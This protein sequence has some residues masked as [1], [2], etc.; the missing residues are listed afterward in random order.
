MVSH[1]VSHT[2]TTTGVNNE[3]D[4]RSGISVHQTTCKLF[5]AIFSSVQV[6]H[7]V[8]LGTCTQCV[9]VVIVANGDLFDRSDR[10]SNTSF[11]CWQSNVRSYQCKKKSYFSQFQKLPTLFASQEVLSIDLLL[12][13][14]SKH[15]PFAD[16]KEFAPWHFSALLKNNNVL[17]VRGR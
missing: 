2:I 6:L 14:I 3:L 17:R 8:S 10:A 4:I 15:L 11:V 5:C 13:A 1:A 16:Y 7:S 12:Q 9:P